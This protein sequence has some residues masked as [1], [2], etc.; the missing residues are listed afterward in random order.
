MVLGGH[1]PNFK[2]RKEYVN[3]IPSYTIAYILMKSNLYS[4]ISLR[5]IQVDSNST[6]IKECVMIGIV[7]K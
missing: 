3:V 5:N 6:Q 1:I 4:F 2:N 7:F